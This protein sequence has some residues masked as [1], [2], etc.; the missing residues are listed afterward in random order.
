[1]MTSIMTYCN[2][3]P[4]KRQLV[5]INNMQIDKRNT[6]DDCSKGLDC[7]CNTGRKFGVLTLEV[8]VSST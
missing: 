7:K 5:R 4:F 8:P 1:M 3:P 2:R 6:H